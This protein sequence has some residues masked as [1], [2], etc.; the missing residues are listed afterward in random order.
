MTTYLAYRGPD[1]V[2]TFSADCIRLG[3][4]MLRTMETMADDRQPARLGSLWITADVRLDCRRDLAD[5]LDELT[6][7]NRGHIGPEVSDAALIL[8][9]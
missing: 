4:A 6:E 8:R 5:K 1:G 3:H 2:N 9:T 7:A